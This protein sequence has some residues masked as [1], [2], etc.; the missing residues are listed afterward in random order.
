MADINFSQITDDRPRV[1]IV[2]KNFV[3]IGLDLEK[4]IVDIVD[5]AWGILASIE[6]GSSRE[7]QI[8]VSNTPD[9]K[10]VAKKLQKF[11]ESSLRIRLAKKV[12]AQQDSLMD[13]KFN[14][15]H[16]HIKYF[17]GEYRK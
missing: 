10:S 1:S 15:F 9:T 16:V 3:H 14:R 2:G 7:I 13:F 6:S 11:F 17:P 4:E 8:S 5:I 12:R